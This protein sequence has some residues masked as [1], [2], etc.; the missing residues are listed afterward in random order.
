MP[1]AKTNKT[2]GLLALASLT[3]YEE[4]KRRRVHERKTNGAFSFV[5]ESLA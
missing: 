4:K 3:P 1:T 5:I 2:L